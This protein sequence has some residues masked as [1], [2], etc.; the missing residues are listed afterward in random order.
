MIDV[1]GLVIIGISGLA[2]GFLTGMVSLG[3]AFIIVPAI[4]QALVLSGVDS[5]TSFTM[6]VATSI[7]FIV[8]SS[9]TASVA[10]FRK[11]MID[12]RLLV[13]IS[14]SSFLGIMIGVDTLLKTDDKLVRI[15]FGIFTWCLGI[16]LVFSKLRGWGKR[17][18]GKSPT[19]SGLNQFVLAII[20][21]CV[22]FL[23][24]IFGIGGGGILAP[25]I[26]LLFKSDIKRALA[27]AIAA[28]LV[29]SVY[30][31]IIYATKNPTNTDAIGAL[32]LG[33]VYLPAL[34]ILVPT[35][36]IAT[37]LGVRVAI[38]IKHNMLLSIMAMI[39]FIMGGRFVFL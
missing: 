2:A 5:H 8:V 21:A 31:F 37:P 14:L 17:H 32:N 19:Y 39:M 23:V 9:S 25:S 36:F 22:G 4:Y 28:T 20:S 24:A 29:I 7:A 13:I 3:G 33:W 16:F 34:A 10:Y 6:A 38:K 12:Y 30:S 35:A 27:T 18:E 15:G 26:A 11:K 1:T